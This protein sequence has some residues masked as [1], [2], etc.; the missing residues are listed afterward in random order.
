MHNHIIN[1]VS[2]PLPSSSVGLEASSIDLQIPSLTCKLV[3]VKYPN[4]SPSDI[5]S[6]FQH[7]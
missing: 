6:P 7:C 3:Q 5:V 2:F 1:P 4:F